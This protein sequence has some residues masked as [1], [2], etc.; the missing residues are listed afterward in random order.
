VSDVYIDCV[1]YFFIDVIFSP[2]LFI[3]KV[4]IEDSSL[5]FDEDLEE[6][7][8]FW[9]EINAFLILED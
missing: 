9:C 3:E 6:M 1:E 8:F 7:E 2:D 5:I 4:S